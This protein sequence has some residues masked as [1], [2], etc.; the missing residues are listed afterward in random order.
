[1]DLDM[2]S[3]FSESSSFFLLVLVKDCMTEDRMLFVVARLFELLGE[4]MEGMGRS[5]SSVILE[6]GMGVEM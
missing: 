4:G 6:E 1:M 2:A 3:H 5:L